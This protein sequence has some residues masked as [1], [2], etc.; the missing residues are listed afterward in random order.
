MQRRRT[1]VRADE[2]AGL[3]W[4]RRELSPALGHVHVD[5]AELAQQGPHLPHQIGAHATQGIADL[6]Q[7]RPEGRG[8]QLQG[9]NK[10]A[11]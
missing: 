7:L 4:N 6:L 1:I 3:C 5:G 11:M 10:S 9:T 2:L 8:C